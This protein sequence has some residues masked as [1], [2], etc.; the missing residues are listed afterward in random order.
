[1]FDGDVYRV[2]RR[3]SSGVFLGS[4][5]GHNPELDPDFDTSPETEEDFFLMSLEETLDSG[6]Y[7]P[8]HRCVC[9]ETIP[10]TAD[11]C[12]RCSDED[13]RTFGGEAA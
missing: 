11:F 1:M 4:A 6:R 8:D 13:R 3:Q 5:A 2:P 12:W 10:V 7:D 9:G